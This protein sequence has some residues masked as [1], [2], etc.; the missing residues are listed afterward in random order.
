V[1]GID[2]NVLIRWLV[3]LPGE[4]VQTGPARRSIE[5][6]RDS[7]FICLPVLAEAVWVL[8]RLYKFDRAGIAQV[9]GG[10]LQNPEVVV[11]DRLAVAQ[12]L[13]GFV[14]GGPCFADHLIGA[15]NRDAGCSTTLTFDK[16]AARLDTFAE[17][18]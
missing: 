18:T 14:A 4:T 12:A 9:V 15:L 13:D 6:S 1:I 2:S 8:T 10:L 11:Q 3:T 17:I 5:A 7:V 16:R